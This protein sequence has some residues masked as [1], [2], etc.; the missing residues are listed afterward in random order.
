MLQ[1]WPNVSNMTL[2]VFSLLYFGLNTLSDSIT[3]TLSFE[4]FKF[5]AGIIKWWNSP[6]SY[7]EASFS[8]Q[9][10]STSTSLPYPPSSQ[11]CFVYGK[12]LNNE[13]RTVPKLLITFVW[14]AVGND[15][16]FYWCCY[17]VIPKDPTQGKSQLGRSSY[18]QPLR[19]RSPS[20]SFHQRYLGVYCSELSQFIN[21][22]YLP[23]LNVSVPESITNIWSL[24][25]KGCQLTCIIL[26]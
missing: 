9:I 11:Q 4:H 24:L 3:G 25:F 5:E 10:Y 1:S 23:A 2:N 14:W 26:F 6:L 8:L 7:L 21:W 20:E 18:I 12:L 15:I 22:S 16:C 13:H 17:H 19:E